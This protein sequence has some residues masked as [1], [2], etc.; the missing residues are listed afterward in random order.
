MKTI[1]RSKFKKGDVIPDGEAPYE[2]EF[3]PE[4][5][6]DEVELLNAQSAD[7]EQEVARNILEI[8]SKVEAATGRDFE[9]P[10]PFMKQRMTGIEA[11]Q[12]GGLLAVPEYGGLKD[13]VVHL[14]KA[15]RGDGGSGWDFRGVKEFT[16]WITDIISETWKS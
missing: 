10:L 5:H 15:V 7:L 9:F 12:R 8:I 16:N 11:I 3:E 13:H 4:S 6:A 2:T 1:R 14:T